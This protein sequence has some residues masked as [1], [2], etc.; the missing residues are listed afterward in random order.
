MSPSNEYSGLIS[1]RMNWFDLLAVQGTLKSLLQHHNSK[2]SILWCCAFMVQLLYLYMTIGKTIALTMFLTKAMSLLLNTVLSRFLIA[3][4][5]RSDHLL[6]S[7][8]QSP[9]SVS[10]EPKKRKS[11]TA[12][13]FSSSICHEVMGQDAMIFAFLILSFKPGF[14]LS[15]LPSSRGSLVPLCFLSLEW[16]HLHICGWWYF[17]L[18]TWFYL[19]THP[20]WHFTWCALHIS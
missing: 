15:S 1:F 3:F 13:T 4:F 12:S 7:W 6:M 8:Q 16:Y 14:S 2:A 17:S 11:V 20:A 10:L 5:P 19:I 18:Q 9:S